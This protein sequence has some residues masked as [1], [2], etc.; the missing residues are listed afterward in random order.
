[1]DDML[2]NPKKYKNKAEARVAAV[3]ASVDELTKLYESYLVESLKSIDQEPTILDYSDI[4]G[5]REFFEENQ[6]NIPLLLRLE[7]RMC[8]IFHFSKYERKGNPNISFLKCLRH[9]AGK[10]PDL[11]F[12]FAYENGY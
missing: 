5:A 6:D 4:D 7:Q 10:L 12:Q 11:D 3:S 8:K 2:Y 1:M 9:D